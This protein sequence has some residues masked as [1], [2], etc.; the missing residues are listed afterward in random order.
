MAQDLV[1]RLARYLSLRP[2]TPSAS[3]RLVEEI[4]T[5]TLTR[6]R[7]DCIGLQGG[8]ESKLL[9]ARSLSL[10]QISTSTRIKRCGARRGS[11]G[12]VTTVWLLREAL[13]V[14]RIR[15]VSYEPSLRPVRLPSNGSLPVANIRGRKRCACP[16]IKAAMGLRCCRRLPPF[17]CCAIS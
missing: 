2:R 15:F 6:N 7:C 8:S 4:P 3:S 9:L 11:L 5:S 14:A 1:A 17:W 16:S 13:S 12:Q 10:G